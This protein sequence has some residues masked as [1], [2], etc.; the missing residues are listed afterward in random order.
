MREELQNA[1][2]EK[3]VLCRKYLKD[4]NRKKNEK[5]L[6]EVIKQKE[7]LLLKILCKEAVTVIKRRVDEKKKFSQ[8]S[9][10]TRSTK[11]RTRRKCGKKGEEQNAER[12]GWDNKSKFARG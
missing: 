12:A 3:K 2:S 4:P 1:L 9:N 6:N 8:R 11:V 5:K 7:E 10:D